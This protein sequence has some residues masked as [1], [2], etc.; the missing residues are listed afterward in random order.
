MLWSL[1]QLRRIL[2]KSAFFKGLGG[3]FT[4]ITCLLLMTFGFLKM[5]TLAEPAGNYKLTRL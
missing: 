5:T 2:A 4:F 1:T 3:H